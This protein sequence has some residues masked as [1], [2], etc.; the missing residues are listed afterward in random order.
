MYMHTFFAADKTSQ[1]IS[2][3]LMRFQILPEI[4]LLL[5]SGPVKIAY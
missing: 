2:Q 5:N 4:D 3:I 1:E